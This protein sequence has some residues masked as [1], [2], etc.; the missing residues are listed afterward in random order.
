MGKTN[1]VA[2]SS[3]ERRSPHCTTIVPSIF[4][5]IE[6]IK[7]YVPGRSK[8]KLNV[9]SVSIAPE[10][11]KPLS[12]TTLCGSSSLFAHETVVPALTVSDIGMN[13][14]SFMTICAGGG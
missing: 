8:R 4:G 13:S 3:I 9:P 11:N 14:K 2:T 6:Q 10:R 12:L 7:W 1:D 5:W